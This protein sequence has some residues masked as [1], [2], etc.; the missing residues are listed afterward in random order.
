MVPSIHDFANTNQN[1]EIFFFQS[2]SVDPFTG[3]FEGL[4]KKRKE[5]ERILCAANWICMSFLLYIL[6]QFYLVYCSKLDSG[7]SIFVLF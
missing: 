7:W 1:S 3:I 6:T 4:W 2:R 5:E